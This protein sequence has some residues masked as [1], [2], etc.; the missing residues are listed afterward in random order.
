MPQAGPRD[1]PRQPRQR[2]R[3]RSTFDRLLGIRGG[4]FLVPKNIFDTGNSKTLCFTMFSED[5]FENS[6]LPTST[7]TAQ[8]GLIWRSPLESSQLSVALS[9]I[10]NPSLEI[11]RFSRFLKNQHHENQQLRGFL[12]FPQVFGLFDIDFDCTGRFNLKV[13][14]RICATVGCTFRICQP[15]P[16]NIKIS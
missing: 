13:A 3:F 16:W 1:P 8:A 9:G 15:L 11:L 14:F 2:Q 7:L 5:T 12:T 6:S 4:S 10:V